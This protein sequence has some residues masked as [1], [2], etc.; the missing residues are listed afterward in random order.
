MSQEN[1]DLAFYSNT[2]LLIST[3]KP[4]PFWLSVFCAFPFPPWTKS[5]DGYVQKP[6]WLPTIPPAELHFSPRNGPRLSLLVRLWQ[7]KLSPGIPTCYFPSSSLQPCGKNK[8]KQTQATQTKGHKN[9]TFSWLGFL[10]FWFLF[11]FLSCRARMLGDGSACL[12]QQLNLAT[13]F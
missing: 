1:W 10:G 9:L 3:L 8:P 12:Y 4:D 5:G 13:H 7:N 11:Y 2:R 6:S